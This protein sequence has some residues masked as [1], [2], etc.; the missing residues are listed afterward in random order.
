MR[1]NALLFLVLFGALARLSIASPPEGSAAA[2]TAAQLRDYVSYIASDEMEG[3]DTPSRGLDTTAGFLATM[4]SRAGLRGGGDDG[5]FFQRIAL[6]RERIDAAGSRAAVG[7]QEFRYGDDF[8]ASAHPGTAAGPLVYVG[9]GW[10]V[11]AKNRDAYQGVD[12]RGKIMLAFAP[13]GL[14][15]GVTTQDMS[16][17][18]GEAWE[19]P[20]GYATRHGAT[21]IIWIPDFQTFAQW[22]QQ[23]R[24]VEREE[25]VV[26]RLE[27]RDAEGPPAITASAPLL[28]AI[29]RGE[30]QNA[31]QIFARGTSNDPGAAFDLQAGKKAS[32]TVAMAT[33]WL[34]TQNVVAILDGSD[35]VL[36][37][38]YVALGAHYDH[39][40]VRANGTGDTVFNGADDDG[41][42][43]AAILAIAEAFARGPRPKRSLLFVWHAGEEQ[44]LW[45]SD[46]FTRF[47][48]VPLDRIVAQLN[49]DMIGRSRREDDANPANRRLT[50][51]DEIYVIGSKRMSTELGQLSEAVNNATQ[52]LRFNYRYDDPNDPERLFFRS[53]HFNYARKGIP[54]I[55]YF[56]GVHEDYH[57]VSDSADKL[58]YQKMEKVTQT[59]Y[60]TAWEIAERPERPRVD[61][62]LVLPGR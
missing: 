2:I 59:I 19:N 16:G 1:R 11:K 6:R 5:S 15:P 17:P 30:A 42:G 40:G 44:G 20:R 41:S 12:V 35:P 60:A 39:V 7:G 56:D 37:G 22:A 28:E 9:D 46:Y 18:E 13:R 54:I 36:K 52:K 4:A 33:R 53:D 61:Q 10:V 45:G 27:P 38:E 23:R 57:R 55:F 62:P 29:F 50:G 26:D 48:T 31:G 8:L 51:P 14:P 43:T 25:T 49:I 58:D 21:G 47:P 34:R 32:F 3:R 24:L